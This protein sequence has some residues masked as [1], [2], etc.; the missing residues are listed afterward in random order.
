MLIDKYKR[1]HKLTGTCHVTHD[2]FIDQI[3]DFEHTSLIGKRLY[4]PSDYVYSKYI[5][6]YSS[7][8]SLACWPTLSRQYDCCFEKIAVLACSPWLSNLILSR[9]I[10]PLI[11]F[12]VIMFKW[13]CF[14]FLKWHTGWSCQGNWLLWPFSSWSW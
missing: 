13:F 6:I 1:R 9:L 12:I 2:L 4:I 3:C 5:K 7:V 10:C 14:L 8:F 11:G